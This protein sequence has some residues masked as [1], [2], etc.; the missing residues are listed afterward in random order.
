MNKIRNRFRRRLTPSDIQRRLNVAGDNPDL[1][2]SG[3]ATPKKDP[4][5]M[6]LK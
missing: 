6:A 4:I 1:R 3:A 2:V 5:K